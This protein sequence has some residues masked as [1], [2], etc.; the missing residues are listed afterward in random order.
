MIEGFDDFAAGDA[1]TISGLA[2]PDTHTLEITTTSPIGD[3]SY[4]MAMGTAAPIPPDDE[5]ERMGVAE[6]HD[7]NYG[8]FLVASGPYMFQGSETMDFS[9]DPK[10]QTEAPGYVPGRQIVLESEPFVD[11]GIGRAT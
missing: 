11:A 7:R 3:I 1:D 2:A 5:G 9:A 6:G 8:R 4:R 10:D